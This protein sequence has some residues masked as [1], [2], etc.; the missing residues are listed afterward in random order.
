MLVSFPARSRCPSRC[1]SRPSVGCVNTS[2]VRMA[3]G[4]CLA[5]LDVLAV[6]HLVSEPVQLALLCL[7]ALPLAVRAWLCN[8][9]SISTIQIREMLL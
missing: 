3:F 6:L 5:V 7:V 8:P 2:A 4:A 1:P 9:S